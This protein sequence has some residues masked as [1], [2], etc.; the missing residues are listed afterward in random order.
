[1]D[2]EIIIYGA[3][4]HAACLIDIIE[5]EGRHRIAGLIDDVKPK[6]TRVWDYSVLGDPPQLSELR[7]A[8]VHLGLVAIGNNRIRQEK[9]EF[10]R[11]QGFDLISIRHPFTSIGRQVIC[12]AGAVIFHGAVIDPYVR[13]GQGVIV[14]KQALIGH[15]S[16]I[17]D[18]VHIAPGVNCGSDVRIGP[19]CLIGIG[20]TILP[21]LTIG[22]DVVIG[23][24]SV[25]IQDVPDRTKVV[26]VPAQAVQKSD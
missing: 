24:G 23:A 20:A 16:V 3:G 8:G 2:E 17:G 22:S 14:N 4:G 25:V 26:G 18:F 9:T 10:L 15:E 12:G 13:I 7:A 1:M 21:R 19:R 5:H 6:G 11:S